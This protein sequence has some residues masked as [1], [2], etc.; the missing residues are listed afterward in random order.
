MDASPRKSEAEPPQNTLTLE[1]RLRAFMKCYGLTRR[2]MARVIR[3]PSGTLGHWLDDDIE[4]PGAIGALLDVL[5]ACGRARRLLGVYSKS[6]A[7]PRGQSATRKRSRHSCPR[8]ALGR[9]N[10]AIR[11]SFRL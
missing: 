4:P 3:T 5:E 6:S 7:A 9:K 8:Y 11:L 10:A 2:E 1:E